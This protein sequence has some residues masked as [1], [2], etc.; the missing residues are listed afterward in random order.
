[1]KNLEGYIEALS[2]APDTHLDAHGA[3]LCAEWNGEDP[4]RFIR[5]LLDLSVR[6][7][8]GSSFTITSM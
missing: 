4:V 1:V 5:D 6:Y 3:R 7:A 8:W 2:T